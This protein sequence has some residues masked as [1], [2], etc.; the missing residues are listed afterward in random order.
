VMISDVRNH[1]SDQTFRGSDFLRLTI[2]AISV[3]ARNYAERLVI[4]RNKKLPTLAE[5]VLPPPRSWDEFE[6]ITLSAGKLRWKSTDLF[7]HGRQGQRQDGV[8]IF[9]HDSSGRHI[10]VQVKNTVEGISMRTVESEVTLAEG[11]KPAIE[12]LFIATTA[13]RDTTI[14]KSVRLLSEARKK[15]RQF[16]VAVLFWQDISQDL[17]SDQ[18]VFLKHY[19]QFRPREDRVREHDQKLFNELQEL[20]SLSGFITFIDQQNMAGFAFRD[21]NLEP[22]REFY[23]EWRKPEREFLSPE[24]EAAKV[25][26][27]AK[28]DE[29]YDVIAHRTFPADHNVDLRYVPPDWE[30]TNP[31][32]FRRSVDSLHT[33]AGEI[34]S[35]HREFVRVGKT[36]LIGTAKNSEK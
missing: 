8:D 7:R 17:A 12:A 29:Y 3:Y 34:V 13:K 25:A 28:A 36:H 2:V 16:P 15:A 20:L 18:E 24:I 9:G 30:I 33:L 27:W 14:Q 35:L 4:E 31:E 21:S 26:L 23:Y 11:F 6:E 32:V 19:P 5:V 10:G 1:Q 22:L